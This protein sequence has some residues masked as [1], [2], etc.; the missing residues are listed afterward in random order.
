MYADQSDAI[1]SQHRNVLAQKIV[2]RI[3]E[4]KRSKVKLLQEIETIKDKFAEW[5]RHM[6]CLE[7]ASDIKQAGEFLNQLVQ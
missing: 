6:R 4:E 1:E 3:A 2:L 5:E 7:L